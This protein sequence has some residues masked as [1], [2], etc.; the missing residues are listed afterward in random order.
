MIKGDTILKLIEEV[1]PAD[2]AKLDEI[3][4]MVWALLTLNGDF[5]ISFGNGGSVYY[6]HNSWPKEAHTVLHHS[7]EHNQYTRSRDALKATRPEGWQLMSYRQYK[8]GGWFVVYKRP[9][10]S[11]ESHWETA[12]AAKLPTEELA[13]LHAIIQA[14]AFERRLVETAAAER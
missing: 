3:D 1:D 11:H 4:A 2:T 13:E 8:D 9:E 5:K 7:F 12:L 6:R 10:E 14:I